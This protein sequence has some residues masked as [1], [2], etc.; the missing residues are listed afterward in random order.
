MLTRLLFF[1]LLTSI[2]HAAPLE[3]K[4]SDHIVW[5]GNTFAERMQYFGEIE[6]RLHA[7][8]PDHNL[9]VR[10]FAGPADTVS[11]RPRPK[12]FR[13]IHHYLTETKADVIP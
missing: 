1:L 7:R 6:G 10:N 2:A 8:Y 4:R 9:V 11:L 12:D 3:I 13:D 5:I